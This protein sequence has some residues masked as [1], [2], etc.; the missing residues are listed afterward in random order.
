MKIN[1]PSRRASLRS[2]KVHRHGGRCHRR[3][4]RLRPVPSS[5]QE[6]CGGGFQPP[7]LPVCQA[8]RL[9]WL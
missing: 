3:W 9:G 5:N 6:H 4:L 2:R 7:R 8:S 1:H